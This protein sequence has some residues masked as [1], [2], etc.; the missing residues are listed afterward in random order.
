VKP[1]L[2]L[3]IFIFVFYA[4]TLRYGH[5]WGDDYAL[6]IHHAKNVATG[7]SYSSIGYLLDPYYPSYS[8]PMA[9]PVFPL[10]LAPVYR[11]FGMNFTALKMEEVVFFV[12]ALAVLFSLFRTYLPPRYGL[13]LMAVIGLNPYFWNIK[14]DILSDIPFFFFLL[15]RRAYG[16]SGRAKEVTAALRGCGVSCHRNQ[17]G[18]PGSSPDHPDLRD[19]SEQASYKMGGNNHFDLDSAS[20]GPAYG[21]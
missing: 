1:Q 16:V 2:W 19:I 11:I 8:V 4:S 12:A 5:R 9:P 18:W 10:L 15:L 21:A 3:L 17:D 13:L 20:Y 6:Y 7:F 14:D